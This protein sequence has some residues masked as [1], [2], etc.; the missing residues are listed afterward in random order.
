MSYLKRTS[1]GLNDIQWDSTL[2]TMYFSGLSS[3]FTINN[4]DTWTRCDQAKLTL[5]R[6]KYMVGIYFTII[7]Q[8]NFYPYGYV[9]VDQYENDQVILAEKQ[10]FWCVSPTSYWNYIFNGITIFDQWYAD[11]IDL[12]IWANS[13]MAPVTFN[14]IELM[15]IKL[16]S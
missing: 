12:Y 1:T 11:S 10:H 7:S 4:Y 8:D 14:T 6:G 9:R 15:A 16:A 3:N 5:S 2:G 13:Y